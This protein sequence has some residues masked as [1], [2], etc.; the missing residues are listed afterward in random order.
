MSVA[1][2][3]LPYDASS[4]FLRGAAQAPQHIRDALHSPSVRAAT[5]AADAAARDA[6]RRA[7]LAF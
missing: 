4:S 3:G 7:P 5:G 2:I 1:I 6:V